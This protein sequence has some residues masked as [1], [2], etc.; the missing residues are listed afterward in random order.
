MKVVQ[1]ELD[2][3]E[4]ELLKEFV[5]SKGVTLKEGLKEVV[6]SVIGEKRIK[7]VERFGYIL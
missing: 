6:L 5:D 4:Y 1:T 7:E 2:E 3:E